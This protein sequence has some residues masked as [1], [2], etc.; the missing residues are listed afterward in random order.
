MGK[1]KDQFA[2][3]KYVPRFLR[4]IWMCHPPMAFGNLILRVFKSVIPVT[5]LFV[6]KLIVD[7]KN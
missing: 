1:I 6:G 2:A 3:L 4:L 5:M 7:A